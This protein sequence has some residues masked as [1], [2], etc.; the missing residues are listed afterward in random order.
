MKC[1]HCKQ[2]ISAFHAALFG[3]PE[4][5]GSRLCP[6]CRK[7]FTLKLDVFRAIPAAASG[8]AAALLIAF[9]IP[10]VGFLLGAFVLVF[11]LY[12]TS[13]R[14]TKPASAEEEAVSP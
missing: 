6:E 8:A 7:P 5:D 3:P 11:S 2:S 9:R 1:P 12:L 13:M 10:Y 14:L 4:S